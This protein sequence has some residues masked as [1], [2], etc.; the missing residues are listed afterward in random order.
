VYDSSA[1]SSVTLEDLSL[2]MSWQEFKEET[3][4]VL[5]PRPYQLYHVHWHGK[6]ENQKV[7]E[8]NYADVLAL[9][10]EES[11]KAIS[12]SGLCVFHLI[13][14]TDISPTLKA[15]I[16]DA[17]SGPRKHSAPG[18]SLRILHST[19][20]SR[21][22]VCVFCCE[23][24]HNRKLEGAHIFDIAVEDS[25]TNYRDLQIVDVN[26]INNILT[27]CSKCHV[28]YDRHTLCVH[29]T[30]E[31]V[32]ICDAFLAYS[33]DREFYSRLAGKRVEKPR[34]TGGLLVWPPK[35][36]MAERY[37]R[38]L[39]WNATRR[40]RNIERP[41]YCFTCNKRYKRQSVLDKHKC[42]DSKM[43]SIIDVAN[44]CIPS[45]IMADLMLK[46]G[47]DAEEDDDPGELDPDDYFAE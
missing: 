26:V 17:S 8:E 1:S 37:K 28:Y 33:P 6:N 9:C 36:V 2:S 11:Y 43:R 24:G 12:T 47:K 29:P 21:D 40:V 10:F 15:F 31:T 18:S 5:G 23:A 16:A 38:Y 35:G 25:G 41:F 20:M 14:T 3:D 44:Y 45:K 34:D 7:T 30:E 39:A 13:S 42:G 27:L 19:A 46:K 4:A 32:E 22:D